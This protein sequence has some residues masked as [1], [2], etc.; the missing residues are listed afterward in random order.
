MSEEYTNIKLEDIVKRIKITD[1]QSYL[2]EELNAGRY[3]ILGALKE[4]AEYDMYFPEFALEAA[5]KIA[6]EGKKENEALEIS[7]YA[8]VRDGKLEPNNPREE[9]KRMFG[10]V[11]AHMIE[12]QKDDDAINLCLLLE[13]AGYESVSV[14]KE[15]TEK[16]T[17][18]EELKC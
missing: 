7:K 3:D 1:A 5:E 17:I 10:R 14:E 2:R 11:L 16:Y 4:Y 18:L 8:N 12:C 13:K 9:T 6:Q 15:M